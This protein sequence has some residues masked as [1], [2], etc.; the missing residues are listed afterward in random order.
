MSEWRDI[1]KKSIQ[2]CQIAIIE[3]DVD[4]KNFMKL[5]N[6]TDKNGKKTYE[7]DKMVDFEEGI[8]YEC[9]GQYEKAIE[10]YKRVSSPGGLP[11]KHWKHRAALF[12]KRAELKKDG[13]I[14]S[15]SF[16][17]NYSML[18]SIG[19]DTLSDDAKKQILEKIQWDA[20]F[21]LHTLVN[22]PSH[23]RYLGI[24]SISRIDSEP[25]MAIVI[26]RTCLE[27]VI[28]I[29]YPVEYRI[30]ESSRKTL[31]PLLVKLFKEGRL[32]TKGKNT[33][34]DNDICKIIKDRG[35]DAAHGNNVDYSPYY[36]CKTIIMFIEIMQKANKL[37]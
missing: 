9:L 22:I 10:I 1:W 18:D 4:G 21:Q 7:K 29:L 36:L 34:F 20:F 31:G 19:F 37:C 2:T 24:S 26:F 6:I 12:L 23:I 17:E 3:K 32:F 15:E 27:G 30:N 5:R 33:I 13:Q 25:E 11:V 35:D 8:A 16:Q 14:F 28:K